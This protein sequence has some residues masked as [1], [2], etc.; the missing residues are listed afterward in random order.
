MMICQKQFAIN[1][2]GP[3]SIAN[4]LWFLN[5]I[6]NFYKQSIV[7]KIIRTRVNKLGYF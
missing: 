4:S 6:V 1:I 5:R 3:L 7:L 2:C